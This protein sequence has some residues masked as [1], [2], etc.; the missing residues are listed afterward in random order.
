MTI[1]I[2][3]W[4]SRVGFPNKNLYF[5]CLESWPLW[6]HFNLSASGDS[7]ANCAASPWAKLAKAKNYYAFTRLLGRAYRLVSQAKWR[8]RNFLC[9]IMCLWGACMPRCRCRPPS[10]TPPRVLLTCEESQLHY[11]AIMATQSAKGP[12]ELFDMVLF[13]DDEYRRSH[14]QLHSIL[15]YLPSGNWS[16][17]QGEEGNGRSARSVGLIKLNGAT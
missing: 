17:G 3:L 9:T 7:R 1:A 16:T 14:T 6:S 4:I 2:P 13:D 15:N 10:S 11:N 5:C 8:Y 12:W